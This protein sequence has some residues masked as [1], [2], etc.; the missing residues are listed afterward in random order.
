MHTYIHTDHTYTHIHIHTY[1]H[2]YI[3][4]DHTY[5]H[6]YTRNMYMY[7]YMHINKC[8]W[9]SNQQSVH[10]SSSASEGY[11]H[12]HIQIYTQTNAAGWQISHLFRLPHQPA[13]GGYCSALHAERWQY[14]IPYSG[15]SWQYH[16]THRYISICVCMQACV[17]ARVFFPSHCV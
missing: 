12:T 16:I 3:H 15:P 6:A 2:A 11:T 4:T 10:A 5:I 14:R 1:I 9:A 13:M 7:T 8:S 17:Y